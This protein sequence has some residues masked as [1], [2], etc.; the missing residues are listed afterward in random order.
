MPKLSRP[1]SGTRTAALEGLQ[2]GHLPSG[3]RARRAR[4]GD[5]AQAAN[6]GEGLAD[7]RPGWPG[8]EPQPEAR[9][10]SDSGMGR[11]HAHRHVTED[12]FEYA[13]TSYPS[14]T[15]IARKI[16]GAH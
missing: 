2:R 12:G 16:T 11:P 8:A 9:R 13:G 3:N 5:P 7:N 1:P 6:D 14:L 4:Q 15:K 10:A